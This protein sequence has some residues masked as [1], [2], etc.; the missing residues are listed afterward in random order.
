MCHPLR[1]G[2]NVLCLAPFVYSIS[3]STTAESRRSAAEQC[4]NGLGA[5]NE[6]G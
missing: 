2:Q 1:C 3:P 6:I 5:L 4:L